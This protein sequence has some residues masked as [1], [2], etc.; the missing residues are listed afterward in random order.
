MGGGTRIPKVQAKLMKVIGRDEL[1]KSINT[2][3]S[4]ALGAVYQAAY[5]STGFKVK[6]FAVKDANIYPIQ[7]RRKSHPVG[8]LAGTFCLYP[9]AI[10]VCN[11]PTVILFDDDQVSSQRLGAKA[12]LKVGGNVTLY[13]LTTSA[14]NVLD[15]EHT[16]F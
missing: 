1:G 10:H 16:I 8:L 3:E 15:S 11:T 9:G 12:E 14:G 5:L 13:L 2:D 7:V 4:A 6:T